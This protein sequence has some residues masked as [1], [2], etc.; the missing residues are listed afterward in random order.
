MMRAMSDRRERQEQ[1]LREAIAAHDAEWKATYGPLGPTE[2][3]EFFADLPP[4][5]EYDD[6][7]RQAVRDVRRALARLRPSE[8]RPEDTHGELDENGYYLHLHVPHTSDREVSLDLIYGDGYLSLT[9]PYGEEHDKWEWSPLLATTVEALLSGRNAQNVHARLGRVFATDTEVW[10]A[11]GRRYRLHRRWRHRH[12]LLGLVP[13]L[14]STQV[15]RS[16]SFDRRP[17]SCSTE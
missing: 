17:R 1:Q 5:A 2:G 4:S 9:W 11:S 16:V 14:P 12:A 6:G 7:Q 13:L 8:V 3:E 15:R 10:D